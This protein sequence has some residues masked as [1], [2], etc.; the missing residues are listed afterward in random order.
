MYNAGVVGSRGSS[1]E[2]EVGVELEEEEEDDDWEEEGI[3]DAKSGGT[4]FL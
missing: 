2:E 4:S 3:G 1:D